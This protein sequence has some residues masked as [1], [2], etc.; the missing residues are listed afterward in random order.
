VADKSTPNLRQ[1]VSVTALSLARR[2]DRLSPGLYL[3]RLLKLPGK[4]AIE[5]IENQPPKPLDKQ[6]PDSS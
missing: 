5:E 6:A 2:V 4:L 1:D 3:I